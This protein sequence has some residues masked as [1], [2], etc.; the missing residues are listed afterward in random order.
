MSLKLTFEQIKRGKTLYGTLFMCC[1]CDSLYF[2]Y[3]TRT[4]ASIV[5]C[6]CVVLCVVFCVDDWLHQL[7]NNL[8]II[9]YRSWGLPK[10]G[11]SSCARLYAI[12]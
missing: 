8:I 10:D 9:N 6:F 3:I 1:L 7:I 11:V 4:N 5:Q 2:P 12:S